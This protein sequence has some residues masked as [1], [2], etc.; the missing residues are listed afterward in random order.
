MKRNLNAKSVSYLRERGYMAAVVEHYNARSR[1]RA[2]LFGFIDVIAVSETGRTVFVQATSASHVADRLRK[3]SSPPVLANA[4]ALCSRA[5][6]VIIGWPAAGDR[7]G[8][9]ETDVT[10]E[11]LT[12]ASRVTADTANILAA[13]LDGLPV[14]IRKS[15]VLT[16]Y[17]SGDDVARLLEAS[18]G[19]PSYV[20]EWV[21]GGMEI[22]VPRWAEMEAK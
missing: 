8:P 17:G 2:D 22:V 16:N 14:S 1:R 6:V 4:I 21:D 5:R 10:P 3:M 20:M 9:R 12:G 11:I 19:I 13:V 18:T 15:Y 7:R